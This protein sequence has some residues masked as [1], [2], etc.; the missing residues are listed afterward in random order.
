MKVQITT[1]AIAPKPLMGGRAESLR[2]ETL[3]LLSKVSVNLF[4]TVKPYT[5]NGQL[6]LATSKQYARNPGDSDAGFGFCIVFDRDGSMGF[7]FNGISYDEDTAVDNPKEAV[8]YLRRCLKRELA[9][10]ARVKSWQQTVQ[11]ASK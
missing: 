3:A 7:D 9:G 5:V 11:V 8:Q 6:V 10:A 4:K 1:A 2:K